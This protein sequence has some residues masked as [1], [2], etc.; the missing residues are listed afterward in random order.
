MA[1]PIIKSLVNPL[2]L[3]EL[4]FAGRARLTFRNQEKGTHMTVHVKQAK[5]KRDRTKKLPIYFVSVSLLGDGDTGYIFAG[6]LFTDSGT[7]KLARDISWNDR[8]GQVVRFIVS[9]LKN[10]EILIEKNVAL[11]HEGRCC[12]C[13]LP[14][15]NPE[16]IDRGLG[17]DC[18][19]KVEKVEAPF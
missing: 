10:P 8:M 4:F 6:T 1:K 14:L 15:T 5:D 7:V 16:S 13:G 19:G 9:A 17:D 12:R 3:P 11:F 2:R 18:Y